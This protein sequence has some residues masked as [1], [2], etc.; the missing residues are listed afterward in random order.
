MGFPLGSV[1]AGAAASKVN[2]AS[3]ATSQEETLQG[4]SDLSQSRAKP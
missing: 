1:D 4:W 3:M 2:E